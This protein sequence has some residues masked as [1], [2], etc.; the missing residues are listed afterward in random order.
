MA[1]GTPFFVRAFRSPVDP[2][3][4]RSVRESI[5]QHAL[6]IGLPQ[7]RAWDVASAADEL[8]CNIDEHSGAA[9]MEISL[10]QG[11]SGPQLRL[12]D[13]G[14]DFDLS[15]AARDAAEPAGHRE[16]GLGLY[17]VRQLARSIEHRRLPD[18]ANETVLH[19]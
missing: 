15:G 8:L 6:G 7:E 18:G 19:F 4:L 10:E 1:S 11:P 12:N 13:D 14:R 5:V 17:V 16:R 9:W 2:E 3:R